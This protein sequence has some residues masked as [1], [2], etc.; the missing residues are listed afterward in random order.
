MKSLKV[1]GLI[2]GTLIGLGGLF[3]AAIVTDMGTNFPFTF[4]LIGFLS[5]LLGFACI[6][7][8]LIYGKELFK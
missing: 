4:F 7:T 5:S 2:L 3:W 8:M 6:E 1:I